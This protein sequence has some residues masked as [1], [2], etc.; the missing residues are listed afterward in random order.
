MRT[1][2]YFYN[3]VG[4]MLIT[5]ILYT[6]CTFGTPKP[7]PS[8]D[9]IPPTPAPSGQEA[10]T[11][12]TNSSK[13]VDAHLD[14]VVSTAKAVQTQLDKAPVPAQPFA[15]TLRPPVQTI[16]TEAVA[17][18]T[19]NE[20]I[21]SAL[22][23]ISH[24]ID[25]TNADTLAQLDS[26]RATIQSLQ[27]DVEIAKAE[28]KAR[29]QII[30]GNALKIWFGIGVFGALVLVV[31]IGLSVK[32]LLYPAAGDSLKPGIAASLI[33]GALIATSTVLPRILNALS[34]SITWSIYVIFAV[35]ILCFL[36]WVV[37]TVKEYIT[38]MQRDEIIETVQ[39]AVV[40]PTGTGRPPAEFST[41]AEAVM[42]PSTKAAVN[43]VQESLGVRTCTSTPTT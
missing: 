38:R 17:A 30:E 16:L 37:Y 35:T 28:T 34:V 6:S 20:A 4:A 33:G 25:K 36:A 43:I 5:L 10:T 1:I 22:S 12:A 26:A 27:S 29:D 15:L 39:K 14:V 2:Q 32:T 9:P 3:I 41:I 7:K 23:Q 13:S 19:T 24:S 8:P 40:N 31:G 18:H 11:P 42:S 21:L